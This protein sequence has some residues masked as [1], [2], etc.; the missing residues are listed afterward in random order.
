MLCDISLLKFSLAI[1]YESFIS[2]G[3]SNF[4][5]TSLDIIMYRNYMKFTLSP[6][7]FFTIQLAS[8]AGFTGPLFCST[9]VNTKMMH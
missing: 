8:F 3:F 2:Q 9:L 1:E 7:I 5:I 4:T 6:V